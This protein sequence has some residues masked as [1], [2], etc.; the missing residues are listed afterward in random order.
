MPCMHCTLTKIEI[1]IGWPNY[2]IMGDT[3][4][5]LNYAVYNF[6]MTTWQFVGI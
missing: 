6:I 1:E 3:Y 4:F 5:L 2:S